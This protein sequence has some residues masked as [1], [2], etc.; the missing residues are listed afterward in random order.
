MSKKK[1][2]VDALEVETFA[3]EPVVKPMMMRP[4]KDTEFN[5]FTCWAVDCTYADPCV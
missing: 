5:E 3:A 1:L 2:A 4:P